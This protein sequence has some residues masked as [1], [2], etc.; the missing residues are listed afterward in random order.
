MTKT[1][2]TNSLAIANDALN[3]E[4]IAAWYPG[5][6]AERHWNLAGAQAASELAA[7]MD[8]H[9]DQW[10]DAGDDHAWVFRGGNAW[11]AHAAAVL[12]EYA[13]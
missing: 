8:A 11:A 5:Y 1:T 3:A 2:E 6:D 12:A 7:W 13:E 10:D 4:G 9:P